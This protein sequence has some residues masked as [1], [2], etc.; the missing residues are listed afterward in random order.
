MVIVKIQDGGSKMAAKKGNVIQS[1][2]TI[3]YSKSESS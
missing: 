2:V 1:G 3:S